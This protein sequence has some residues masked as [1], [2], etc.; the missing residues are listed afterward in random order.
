M[1]SKIISAIL[2]V[3][4]FRIHP[5]FFS[6]RCFR[7]L[8]DTSAKPSQDQAN[9]LFSGEERHKNVLEVCEGAA[10]NANQVVG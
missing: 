2:Y 3:S 1:C 7:F 10:H 8:I 5:E 6:C 9:P 4:V